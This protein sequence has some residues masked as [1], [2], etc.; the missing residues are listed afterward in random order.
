MKFVITMLSALFFISC[1]AAPDNPVTT[2]AGA[3]IE[4]NKQTAIK[5]EV[6]EITRESQYLE[7][8]GRDMDSYRLAKDAESHRTCTALME[9]R[10]KEIADL[11]ARI[12]NL[13]DNYNNQLTPIIIDLR[14]CVSCS[15][16]AMESCVKTRASINKAIKE[17]FPK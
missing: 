3:K 10:G 17:I 6:S 5:N 12:K 14:E 15:K 11:E 2:A 9:D 13:P 16:T 8:I 4:K 1:S 7:R